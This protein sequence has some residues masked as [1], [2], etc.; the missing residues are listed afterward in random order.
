MIKLSEKVV[1]FQ[2]KSHVFSENDA[3]C[4]RFHP[5]YLPTKTVNAAKNGDTIRLHMN[6]C[7]NN[8]FGPV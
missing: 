3:G 8:E 6:Q 4:V 2:W 7:A 5:H 1:V